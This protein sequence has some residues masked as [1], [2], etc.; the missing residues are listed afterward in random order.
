[1]STC[2]KPEP[3]PTECPVEPFRLK[4]DTVFV[5]IGEINGT[6]LYEPQRCVNPDDRA[7]LERRGAKQ[8]IASPWATGMYV[9]RSNAEAIRI[10]AEQAGRKVTFDDCPADIDPD[11]EWAMMSVSARES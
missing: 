3:K 8:A 1:M 10:L 6:V 5:K 11:Q 7:W 4:S 9:Q 2:P